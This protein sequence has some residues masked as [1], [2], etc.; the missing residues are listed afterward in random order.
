[1]WVIFWVLHC[2][3]IP[4]V[5]TGK[6]PRLSNL[7]MTVC[8]AAELGGVSSAWVGSLP[9]SWDAKA[10]SRQVLLCCCLSCA[11]HEIVFISI[12][13]PEYYFGLTTS[14]N[15]CLLPL[16]LDLPLKV[17]IKSIDFLAFFA[18][19]AA[20]TVILMA[21]FSNWVQ[22]HL[23]LDSD[24]RT[25]NARKSNRLRRCGHKSRTCKT[26]PSK[27]TFTLISREKYASSL[28]MNSDVFVL[29]LVVR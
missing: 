17:M 21:R 7:L 19:V 18:W 23:Q 1:M 9:S 2:W 26:L 5:M 6:W 20:K 3:L 25:S 28:T 11:R 14:Y 13:Y 24:E 22:T 4:V 15:R 10:S 29:E 8:P 16:F 27:W 12:K